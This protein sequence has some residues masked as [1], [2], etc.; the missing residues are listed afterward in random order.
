M[1]LHPNKALP[2]LPLSGFLQ[3][4]VPRADRPTRIIVGGDETMRRHTLDALRGAADSLE[5]LPI[6]ELGRL[7][8]YASVERRLVVVVTSRSDEVNTTVHA[9]R[10]LRARHPLAQIV[11][12][13]SGPRPSLSQL[14]SLA[15]SGGDT[16]VS[17]GSDNQTDLLR[18]QVIER[19]RHI[20]PSAVAQLVAPRRSSPVA[21]F[22][23]WCLRNAYQPLQVE[24]VSAF[25]GVS[26]K[27]LYRNARALGWRNVEQLLRSARVLHIAAELDRRISTAEAIA[28]ELR[29]GS[30]AAVH[31]AIKRSTGTTLSGLRE[32]GAVVVVL[33][34]WPLRGR[35]MTGG[36][37]THAGSV[38]GS[39]PDSS[40]HVNGSMRR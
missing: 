33:A 13:L 22:E 19:V 40:A 8:H 23:A 34:G 2:G 36:L 31:K 27:T 4:A 16:V 17:E 37:T 30:G 25:F 21:A 20:L 10:A 24:S 28:R 26:R 14:V 6:S 1:Y 15:R 29:F 38:D 7:T 39:T 11:P 18:R 32:E 5:G 35:P 12:F 9:I 3:D